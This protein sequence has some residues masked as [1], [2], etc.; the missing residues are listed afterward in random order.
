MIGFKQPN[1]W[2]RASRKAAGITAAVLGGLVVLAFAASAA[3]AQSLQTVNTTTVLW[4]GSAD[5]ST[6]GTGGFTTPT[7]GVI[8]EG[9]AVSE[10]RN[11]P[12]GADGLF[13]CQEPGAASACL[14][15]RHM[16]YGDIINGLCRIDPEIDS[17]QVTPV[18]G[19]GTFNVNVLTCLASVQKVALTPGQITFD[20]S[21]NTMYTENTSRV[22]AG[23]LRVHYLPDG[24]KGQGSVDL[25]RVD[26]LIGTQL[27]R[28]AFGGCP[29]LTDPKG[30][31]VPIV[32]DA[33][34]IGPDGNLYVGDIRNG[35][36]LRIINPATFNTNTDCVPAGA[37]GQDPNG[38]IQIP[39]LSADERFGAGH[40]FGLGWIG[41][42]LFG[43]DNIA[44]WVKFNADQCLTPANGNTTCGAP[45]IGGMPVPTE[46]LAA[47]AGAPQGGLTTDAQYPNFPGNAL[48]VG[49]FPNVTRVT[50]ILDSSTMKINMNYGGGFS[51]VT[52]LTADPE[53]PSNATLYVG[54]DP[55]QGGINGT[56]QIWK[57]TPVAAVAGPPATP[58]IQLATA[59]PGSGQATLVWVP[60]VN[61]EPTTS[62]TV[63][64]LLAST[65]GG[66]PT[67]STFA[68]VTLG[69]PSTTGTINGLTA[70]T[71]YQFQLEA[72]NV[73]GCSAF[74]RPSGIVTPFTAS[75]PLAPINVTGVDAGDSTSAAIAWT[76]PN[77][78]H[79]PVTSSLIT[80][81]LGASQVSTNTVFGAGTGGTISGLTCG[82]SYTFTVTATNAIGTGA[83]SAAS[84]P[85]AISCVTASDVLVTE[86]GPASVNAGSQVTFT[87]TVRNGGPATAPVVQLIDVL[88]APLVNFTTS[89]GACA[90]TAGLTQFRCNLGSIALGSTATVKVTIV[91]PSNQTSGSVTNSV[92]VT[93]T[94][95]G[96]NNVDTNPANNTAS[97]TTSI[98]TPQLLPPPVGG[99]GGGGTTAGGGSADIEVKGSAQNGGPNVGQSDTMTWQI[100]NNTGNTT[101]SNVVFTL[102]MPSSFTFSS[103][104]SSIG[105]CSGINVGNSG[106]TLTCTG[107]SLPGGQTMLVTVNFTPTQAG[108]ISASGS[109]T[110]AGTDSQP[111][112]NSFTVTIQPR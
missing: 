101:V 68:D 29:R 66:P 108:P 4:G 30:S 73:N 100:K 74:T 23:A 61:N 27:N 40:T 12:K 62:Y 13:A 84:G 56:G 75:A 88:P 31:P 5:L 46:I 98:A 91:L 65:T 57:V 15:V 70:G 82:N 9:T 63:R 47:Q 109:A 25:I 64:I 111:G 90:G 24:D 93:A 83:A 36:I 34:A 10:F 107:A 80:A 104:N 99:G 39:V 102:Q 92:S 49:S 67:P 2:A 78:G 69:A 95:A 11:G 35:S 86:S 38:K 81:F 37:D 58:S 59:G 72:C 48:Y 50:N 77:N 43:A 106:G 112:N 71:G 22:A 6:F 33:A 79:S 44:P 16:W 53:D 17:P 60:S 97:V 87:I 52:G 51:F 3:N 1:I 21:T 54:A 110:F 20:A 28:N 105:S 55:T 19:F 41:H 8:V 76:M 18:N 96:G 94:D 85:V 89:Q 42:T 14:P 7:S 103:A 45:V 26:S 32:P